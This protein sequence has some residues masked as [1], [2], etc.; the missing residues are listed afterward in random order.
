MMFG[1][2]EEKK[3]SFS[4]FLD[5]LFCGKKIILFSLIVFY[6]RQYSRRSRSW[7]GCVHEDR[8][9]DEMSEMRQTSLSMFSLRLP[10]LAA[11]DSPI[12]LPLIEI[13][14]SFVLL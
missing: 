6:S 12:E 5:G 4:F 13:V 14:P 9:R 8:I 2:S 10:P 3:V 1:G 7:S 11:G